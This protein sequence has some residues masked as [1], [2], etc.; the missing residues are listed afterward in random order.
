MHHG[1]NIFAAIKDVQIYLFYEEF[2][3]DMAH[4]KRRRLAAMK[5]VPIR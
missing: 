3:R 4:R 1:Q 2:V 5:D